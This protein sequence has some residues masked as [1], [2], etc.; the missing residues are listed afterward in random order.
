MTDY[1]KLR[2]SLKHLEEQYENFERLDE[3]A[4]LTD[5]DRDAIA[6]SV[7]QRFETF[8]DILWTHRKRYLA[9]QLVHTA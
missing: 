2:K 4:T 6:E 3:R 8:H 7:I 9:A 1:E 5:R